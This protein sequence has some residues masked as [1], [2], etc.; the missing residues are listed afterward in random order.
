MT[1]YVGLKPAC[2]GGDRGGGAPGLRVQVRAPNAPRGGKG[3]AA[4][5][6]YLGLNAQAGD[7]AQCP[8]LWGQTQGAGRGVPREG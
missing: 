4:P 3:G 6:G 8:G 5:T 7:R 1:R 2:M